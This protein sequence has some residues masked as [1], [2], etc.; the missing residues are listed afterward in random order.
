M[1][2]N[3]SVYI[4]IT[5]ND[6]LYIGVTGRKPEKRWQKGHGYFNN[7]HFSSAIKKYGWDNIQHIIVMENISSEQAFEL[8]QELIYK[9]DS[10]NR[11]RGYNKSIGGDRGSL[12]YKHTEETKKFISECSKKQNH[13]PEIIR[14]AVEKRKKPVNVYDLDGN[15]IATCP[16]IKE[17]EILTG[18]SNSCITATCKGRYEQTKGYIFRYA[19]DKRKIEKA[20]KNTN[21]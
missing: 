3:Y 20:R 7:K 17:A 4:H 14:N 12:G 13:N 19:S 18:V 21:L 6:K 10:A 1:S 2:N 5:P 9:Y 15:L 8:E 16:S 11:E